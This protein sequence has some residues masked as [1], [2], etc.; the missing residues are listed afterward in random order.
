MRIGS[1]S[2]VGFPLADRGSGDTRAQTADSAASAETPAS[3][4]SLSDA[5]RER[6]PRP[7]DAGG[8]SAPPA[9]RAPDPKAAHAGH[10]HAEDEAGAAEGSEKPKDGAKPEKAGAEKPDEKPKSAGAKELT[11]EEQEVVDKLKAR[12]AEVRAHEQAHKAVGGAYAGPISY[13]FQHGP[14]DRQYAVGGSVPID[15][16]PI[17]GDPAATIQK[18][19]VVRRAAM[20][21]ADP[22]GADHQVAASASAKAAEARAQLAK[23]SYEKMKGGGEES[24]K[25]GAESPSEAGNPTSPQGAASARGR[26][27]ASEEGA[28][29]VDA[30]PTEQATAV[31]SPSRSGAP[32]ATSREPR[33]PLRIVA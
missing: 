9:Q 29:P 24:S 20:A 22:S 13:D 31:S 18:M 5:A 10:E 27:A 3:V 33:A 23:Q 26:R 6:R 12:D 4:L 2:A 21:P 16:S 30:A 7:S 11:A 15:T 1:L 17:A 32:P 25:D 8:A 28:P 19:D 14:D